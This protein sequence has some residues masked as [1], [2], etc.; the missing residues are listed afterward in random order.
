MKGLRFVAGSVVVLSLVLS[1]GSTALAQ[2]KEKNNLTPWRDPNNPK[3]ILLDEGYDIPFVRRDRSK[4]PKRE[5]GPIN[6]QRYEYL[7]RKTEFP[8]YLG[9]PVA[10]TPEDLK[11]GKVDV[12]IVGLPNDANPVPGAGWAANQM[13]FLRDYGTSNKGHD[14]YT[15]ID[16][17]KVLNA[18]DYG[19]ST[20]HWQGYI[21]M[22]WEEHAKIVG[23]ILDAGA[24][25]LAVGGDHSTTNGPLMALVEH[26]GPKS[27]MFVHFDA[28]H[29]LYQSSF[30]MFSHAGRARRWAYEQ[31]WLRG[32]DMVSI[33][34][35]GP[36]N[37]PEEVLAWQREVGERYHYMMEF[38]RDGFETVWQR[39]LEETKGKRIFITFD[40][41]VIDPAHA[42]GVSNSTPGGFTAKEAMRM[43]REL[44]INAD[45]LGISFEEYNP[46][47]DDRHYNTAL[48]VDALM[49]SHLAGKAARKKGI[50][51][52]GYRTPEFLDHGH[53]KK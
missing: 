26:Y 51:D 46:F 44:T 37:P 20:V 4:D 33:G 40:V 53:R 12:A 14:V 38:E 7:L 13:R 45:V 1:L 31:G 24:S 36:Y 52:P 2:S 28:H 10:F 48:M 27:F 8:T 43:V 11:A 35:R 32:E 21:Q 15:N 50:T 19:N 3:I 49:R 16:Y 6:M 47:M 23:E 5:P 22:N 25:F 39:I 42:P 29:D 34:L 9:L 41:D 18:V 30:G 17:L